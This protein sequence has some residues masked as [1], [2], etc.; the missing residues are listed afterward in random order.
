MAERISRFSFHSLIRK[1]ALDDLI[2]RL[3]E[4]CRAHLTPAGPEG[5]SSPS[6]NTSAVEQAEP[7]GDA[8]N[9]F[10]EPRPLSTARLTMFA[11]PRAASSVYS[12]D[13]ERN[14]LRSASVAQSISKADIGRHDS[15]I[16]EPSSEEMALPASSDEG[17]SSTSFLSPAHTSPTTATSDSVHDE[18]DR[19]S[20]TEKQGPLSD[21]VSP[22]ADLVKKALR[23]SSVS[24]SSFGHPWRTSHK[25]T[26]CDQD[27][28]QPQF[29][30]F[31]TALAALQ[32]QFENAEP[33]HGYPMIDRIVQTGKLRQK[34]PNLDF[35]TDERILVAS[36]LT[37]CVPL[38]KPRKPLPGERPDPEEQRIAVEQ[39]RYFRGRLAK[40]VHRRIALLKLQGRG[41]SVRQLEDWYR[42]VG[43]VVGWRELDEAAMEWGWRQ[44]DGFF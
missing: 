31:Q 4:Q 36:D 6:D 33:Q 28:A 16:E 11:P 22:L 42:E 8:T 38:P 25:T 2:T 29:F 14:T 39:V 20:L 1:R 5:V 32:Q 15:I 21:P 23:M 43:D 30:D 3:A 12:R 40:R 13:I 34:I 26:R 27:K 10:E 41:G 35:E 37:S 19:D 17:G 7:V 18:P 44:S 24:S 9:I